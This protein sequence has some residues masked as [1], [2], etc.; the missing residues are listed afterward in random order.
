MAHNACR[1]RVG[2][3]D[4]ARPILAP[5]IG[6]RMGYGMDAMTV[7]FSRQLTVRDDDEILSAR[8]LLYLYA[9]SAGRRVPQLV[10]LEMRS[11][12]R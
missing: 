8:R 11:I 6:R 3:P 10:V 1:S 5:M 4:L 12:D 7:S 2:R 9:D